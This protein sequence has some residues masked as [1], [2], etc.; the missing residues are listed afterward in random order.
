MT[1]SLNYSEKTVIIDNRWYS[2]KPG[3]D[4]FDIL[5]V[6]E[7]DFPEINWD[8]SLNIYCFFKEIEKSS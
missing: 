4:A 6:I 5:N 7:Y 1:I 8:E 2:W 3:R